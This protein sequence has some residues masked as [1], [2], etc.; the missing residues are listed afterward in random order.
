MRIAFLGCGYVANMYRLSLALHPELQ[1]VGCFDLERSRMETMAGATGAR[2][3]AGFDDFLNGDFDIALNLTNP[4]A[5]FDTTR[6]LLEAGKHVYTEKPLALDF[7]EAAALVDLAKAKNLLLTSAPCTLFS[8]TAQTL[9]RAVRERA[10]GDVRLAYAEMDD[11][12]VPRAPVAKWINELG[13]AWPYVDEFETGCTIEHAGYVLTWMCAFFGP[14]ASI[15]GFSDTLLTDK[16]P[17]ERIRE[18]P[19]FSVACVKFAGGPVL[20]MT[21]GLYAPHD[22]RLRLFAD[23]GVLTVDD[24]RSDHSPV[25]AQRYRTVRRKRFLSPLKRKLPFATSRT[26]LAQYR[27]SQ[28]RDFCRGVADMAAAIA[29]GGT[30]LMDADFALHVCEATLACHNALH[31]GAK[32]LAENDVFRAPYTPTSRFAP[33]SPRD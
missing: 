12:M 1:L 32:A 28:S 16:V 8:P 4:R 24:P 2:A 26:R 10:V 20:R 14:A 17:G 15:S 6:A 33:I 9:W 11:G 13:V 25:F 31:P 23:E 21:N 19:D 7:C 27:G 5:H 22:H 3:Y 18:A 30:P 29:S